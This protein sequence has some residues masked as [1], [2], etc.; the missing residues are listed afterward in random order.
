MSGKCE[1]RI[2]WAVIACAGLVCG[3]SCEKPKPPA[4]K[5]ALYCYVGGTMEPAM[6]ELAADWLKQTGQAV[7]IDKAD[8]G[9][10]LVKIEQTGKGDLYIAHDPFPAA[11]RKKG[12][13]SQSF[14]VATLTP[15]IVVAKGNPKG[16]KGLEDLAKPGV[17]LGLTDATYSTLGHMA[18]FM[19]NKAGLQEAIQK[20][21]TTTMREGG[22]IANEVM[23]GHL[24]AAIVWNAVAFLRRDKLDAVPIAAKYL[25]AA[26][27][28]VVTSAT[29]VAAFGPIDIGRIR[30][31]LVT[32]K[33]STHPQD[34]EAFAKFVASPRGAEVFAKYDFS[35]AGG[36]SP[37]AAPA[38]GAAT[39]AK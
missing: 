14:V 19:F 1:L 15:V 2:A 34:A 36:P 31:E 35:P 7:D 28:D 9:Q 6:K 37:S 23:L 33:S 3:A 17:R 16:I 26:G 27:V 32:L 25:P 11:A 8:S 38:S 4:G 13:V 12:L 24:D 18:P 39:Q 21:V 29:A 5:P 22:A 30:V 10:C 20:N